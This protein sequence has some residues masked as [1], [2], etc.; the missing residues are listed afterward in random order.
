MS[1]QG[2][3][4]LPPLQGIGWAL[5]HSVWQGALVGAAVLGLLW[6]TR[7]AA[8]ALRVRLMSA[9]LAVML[10]WAVF[11]GVSIQAMWRE[12]AACWTLAATTPRER[13]PG[14]CWRHG[15][16]PREMEERM[17]RNA[18]P[19]GWRYGRMEAAELR[20]TPAAGVAALAWLV[21]ALG[22]LVRVG[23]GWVRVVRLRSRDAEPI[24]G[25]LA[26]VLAGRARRAGIRRP[27]ALVRSQHVDVPAVIGWRRPVILM[28]PRVLAELS[29]AQV[30]AILVHELEHVRRHDYAANIAQTVVQ[31]VLFHHPVAHWICRRIRQERE[32]CC[33]EAAAGAGPHHV[34]AY[35]RALVT[36]DAL[37]DAPTRRYALA[38]TGGAL[39]PRVRRLATPDR[40]GALR[41]WKL[42]LAAALC[43]ALGLLPV[44]GT[45]GAAGMGAWAVM[46]HDLNVRDQAMAT[47]TEPMLAAPLRPRR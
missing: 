38:A 21:L 7:R 4:A 18:P 47:A 5:L 41:G 9:A 3:L 11:T 24:D 22:L 36:V 26:V 20:L 33:D 6:A 27:V 12:H 29:P 19:G 35:V 45:A 17:A 1:P 34:A 2:V 15:L 8:P 43:V 30:E 28:P 46:E 25:P 16:M 39:L 37:R 14:V 13:L 42:A 10:G 32:F 23:A 40:L 44:V 31:A